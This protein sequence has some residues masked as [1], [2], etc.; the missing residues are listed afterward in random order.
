M[1]ED[2]NTEIAEKLSPRERKRAA[3]GRSP[4]EER[5]E[6]AEALL[7]AIVA[8]A[9]AWGGYQAARWDGRQNEL[10]G[11][12]S[13]VR[14]DA[15]QTLTLGGQRRLFDVVTFNTWIEA[16]NEGRHQLADLYERRFSP[17][18][19]VAFDA[20]IPRSTRS[21]TPTRRRGRPSCPNTRTRSFS[22]ARS[23]TT[24]PT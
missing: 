20:W 14:S 12:A 5:V 11:D 3:A 6:I 19:K 1:P 2:L 18:F 23:W 8:V 15:D 4:W 16:T 22:R 21:R 9:T 17:E 10:Y 24:T 13:T 7:L